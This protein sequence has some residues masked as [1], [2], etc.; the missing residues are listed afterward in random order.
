MSDS[1]RSFVYRSVGYVAR[2]LA[3]ASLF[4][5]LS[6]IYRED[7]EPGSYYIHPRRNVQ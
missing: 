3:I 7:D 1:N 6:A 4:L 2:A 5:I